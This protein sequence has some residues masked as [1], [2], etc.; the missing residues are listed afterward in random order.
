MTK[1]Y[2]QRIG[3]WGE[4]IAL[5]W[6]ED[7]GYEFVQ[8][9]FMHQNDEI[10]LIMIKDGV[11]FFVEVKTR[12]NDHYGLAEY[13]MTKKKLNALFRCIDHYLYEQKLEDVEWQLDLIVVEKFDK[14]KEAE[15]LHFERLGLF[16]G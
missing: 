16:D 12:R 4:D 14:N 10:D 1:T 7:K 9:N 11:Y 3:Q 5:R 15:I 6:L 8:R 2:R 13:A